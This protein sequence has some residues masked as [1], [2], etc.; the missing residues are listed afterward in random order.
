MDQ[1]FQKNSLLS[2]DMYS[3]YSEDMENANKVTQ[4]IMAENKLLLKEIGTITN[5][6]QAPTPRLDL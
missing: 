6:P 4:S 5:K 3:E 1:L 2:Q